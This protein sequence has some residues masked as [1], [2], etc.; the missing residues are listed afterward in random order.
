MRLD[1]RLAFLALVTLFLAGVPF[2][3]GSAQ[4]KV[5][6]R[7]ALEVDTRH[8]Y[9]RAAEMMRQK[10]SEL[11][12]G[13]LDI[14]VF[15]SAQLGGS[16]EMVEG[17]QVGTVEMAMPTAAVMSRVVKELEVLD[18]PFLFRDFAHLHAYLDGAGGAEMRAAALR[19]GIRVLGFYTG[20]TRGVYG[21][22]PLRGMDDLKGL[23]VRTLEAPIV[24]ATWRA[25]GA[26]PTPIPFP[27]VYSAL[28]SGVVDAGEGNIVTY[29]TSKLD[30]VA[31]HVLHIRYLITVVVVGIAEAR[32]QALPADLRAPLEQAFRESLA[33]ER[34]INEEEENRNLAELRSKGRTVV[35]PDDLA[36]YQKAVQAVYEQYG[37]GIGP[38]KIKQIQALR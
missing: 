5:T 24:T 6:L 9:T 13:R 20:G 36:P 3:H 16:R 11:T 1:R 4:E 15:P 28:Q 32:W 29:R 26:I 38:E 12:N 22:K 18:L 17:M 8:P 10:A 19:R 25:L 30:E 31:P 2:P 23:K 7:Y 33:F 21:R 27:E 37:K 34:G 35:V 14:Q